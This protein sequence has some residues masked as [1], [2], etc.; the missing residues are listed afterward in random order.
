ME[1]VENLYLTLE[2]LGIFKISSAIFVSGIRNLAAR[3]M[4]CIFQIDVL[5]DVECIK[6]RQARNSF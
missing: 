4:L 3:R 2:M 6:Y 5:K 1:K